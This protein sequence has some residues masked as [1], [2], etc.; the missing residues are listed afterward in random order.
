MLAAGVSS[1]DTTR[2]YAPGPGDS[3]EGGCRKALLAVLLPS[4]YCDTPRVSEAARDGG[5][6]VLDVSSD[7]G[8]ASGVGG[9]EAEGSAA[10][11]AGTA[12]GVAG[13]SK[14]A[15]ASL[16]VGASSSASGTGSAPDDAVDEAS[17]FGE[18][19]AKSEAG[20][21]AAIGLSSFAVGAV[22]NG[23]TGFS[24]G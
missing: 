11:V 16:G 8:A 12:N 3:W 9:S 1:G 7:C 14:G 18:E 22:T 13:D 20:G 2:A 23:S 10:G 15:G 4:A 21:C 17:T 5:V 6:G 24:S 19:G